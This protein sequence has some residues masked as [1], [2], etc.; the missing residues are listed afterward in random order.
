MTLA[1][2]A[3]KDP[4]FPR[5]YVIEVM[6]KRADG[7]GTPVQ[8]L[9]LGVRVH[10]F[11]T[12]KQP[13]GRVSLAPQARQAILLLAAAISNNSDFSVQVEIHDEP[14]IQTPPR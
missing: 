8:S 3:R 10:D 12:V 4:R 7:R 2:T 14:Q 11:Q 6:D 1:L 9:V 5:Y 13:G